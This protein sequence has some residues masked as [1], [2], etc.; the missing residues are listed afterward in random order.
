MEDLVCRLYYEGDGTVTDKIFE[1]K[2]VALNGNLIFVTFT[3]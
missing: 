2:D 3:K 1:S